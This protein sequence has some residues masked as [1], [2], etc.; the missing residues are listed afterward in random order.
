MNNNIKLIASD[1]DG[2]LLNDNSEISDYNKTILKNL[3]K[4]VLIL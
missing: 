4:K 2:T 3:W 1:L